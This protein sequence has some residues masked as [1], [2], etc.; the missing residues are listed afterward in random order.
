MLSQKIFATL[1][2]AAAFLPGTLARC[3]L[4][5]QYHQDGKWH[6]VAHYADIGDTV[7]IMGHSTTI[8]IRCQPAKPSE[9]GLAN[10]TRYDDF[11][12]VHTNLNN[13]YVHSVAQFLPWHRLFVQVYE[14]ALHDCGFQGVMPYWDWSLDTANVT[15]SPIWDA[16]TGF[17]GNGDS[18]IDSREG[19]VKK[20]LVDGPFAGPQVAWTTEGHNPHC[21]ARN[22]NNGTSYPG[23]MFSDN[24]DNKTIADI[25]ALDNY[26]DFRYRLEGVPHGAFHSAIGG[27]MQQ[28]KP[29]ER[30]TA[31]GG[32]KSQASDAPEATVEDT[33]S[34]L[35]LIPDI[36]IK[37]VMS[38]QP[39]ILCYTY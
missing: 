13:Q 2:L 15:K 30:T 33:M 22:W 18:A 36:K 32:P 23:N 26:P 4:G 16:N 9:M 25:A 21:L 39:E 17:G 5:M 19:S 34:Y 37:E 3:K 35:G 7:Y 8:G 10:I 1:A 27:D 31:F 29:E 11:T 12:C 28:A 24:Y 38:T 14:N 6:Y 20:C